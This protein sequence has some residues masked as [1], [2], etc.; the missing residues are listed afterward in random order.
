[1]GDERTQEHSP[2]DRPSTAP[3]CH[4]REE[5]EAWGQL[6]AEAIALRKQVAEINRRLAESKGQTRTEEDH[7][8]RAA[9]GI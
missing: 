3:D 9:R 5:D 8:A 2:E 7:S 4:L 1:M 6:L